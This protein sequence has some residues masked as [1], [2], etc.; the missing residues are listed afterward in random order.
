MSIDIDNIPALNSFDYSVCHMCSKIF[1]CTRMKFN[2]LPPIRNGHYIFGRCYDCDDKKQNEVNKE[3]IMSKIKVGN[4]RIE[5]MKNY[6]KVQDST[7][8]TS[9][10]SDCYSSDLTDSC[11][12]VDSVDSTHDDSASCSSDEQTDT[13]TDDP[14][15]DKEKLKKLKNHKNIKLEFWFSL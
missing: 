1:N 15:L 11:D 2:N 14:V 6:L 4:E 8:D 9:K 12:D 13:D 10:E 7:K 5:E 3:Q